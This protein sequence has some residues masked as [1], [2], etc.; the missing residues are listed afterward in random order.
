[1]S[2]NYKKEL[3]TAS[4][5]MIM[6]HEPET[7][8]KLIVRMIVR[9]VKIKY[10]GMILYDAD[11]E[12]YVLSISK[13]EKGVKVPANFVRFNKDSPV[14]KLFTRP[15]YKPLTLG[16]NALLTEDLNKLIWQESVFD[17]GNGSKELLHQII[18]QMEMFNAVACVPAY[19]RDSLLAVLLLG[20][21]IDEAKFDQDELDFF[22]ALASDAAM[23]IKN[24]RLFTDLKVE[25]ERN[26]RLFIKTATVL[27]ST[28]E[29]KDEYTHGHTERVTKYAMAIARYLVASDQLEYSNIFFENLYISGLLHDIGKIGVPETILCK[30]DKLT[31]E[32][33]DLMKK[34]PTRG[35]EILEPL[36]EEFQDCM[37]AIK[38]HHE[39]YDG[40]GYPD[41]LEGDN[42]PIV[43]AI[44]AV[45]DAYDAMT[46]DRPYRKG[47]S[48][49]IAVSEIEKNLGKQFHPI[50]AQAMIE[51]AK[52][53]EV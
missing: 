41:G 10:A 31:D 35:V 1:M 30:P 3:E 13:G 48:K 24:A 6:I 43:A 25:A 8:I 15:E 49:E 37:K 38:H 12:S 27:G 32:E 47:L 40:R 46:T 17:A 4:K 5:G 52:R 22:A 34:H 50:P 29:A 28:I 45:A 20:E 18:E 7:L 39:R 2:V 21:K 44:I 33:F 26:R 19:Y 36:A 9:K 14:I 23:A 11:K 53:G 42:I 51:L 16:R